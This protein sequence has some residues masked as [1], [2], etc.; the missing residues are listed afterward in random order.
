[1]AGDIVNKALDGLSAYAGALK[2]VSTKDFSGSAMKSAVTDANAALG[3][4]SVSSK[5]TNIGKTLPAPLQSLAGTLLKNYAEHQVGQIVTDADPDVTKILDGVARYLDALHDEG[6]EVMNRLP[7]VFDSVDNGLSRNR[8]EILQVFDVAFRWTLD[9]HAIMDTQETLAGVVKKLQKAEAALAAAGKQ[10]KPD[11]AP[12]LKTV[13]ENA[14]AVVSD[15]QG[16][17]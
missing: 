8:M 12:E 7:D 2:T 10:E 4:I 6:T 15:I 3:N 9:L 14:F 17:R 11:A 1:M 16:A 13:S 5:V